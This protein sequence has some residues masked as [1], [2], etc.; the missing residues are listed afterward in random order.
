M[1]PPIGPHPQRN[2]KSGGRGLCAYTSYNLQTLGKDI[3]LYDEPLG[4]LPVHLGYNT[5]SSAGRKLSGFVLIC[6][7]RHDNGNQK[8]LNPPN[9]PIK[10]K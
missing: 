5:P 3:V 9:G 10:I 4:R 6:I 2:L 1:V 8:Q 7:L